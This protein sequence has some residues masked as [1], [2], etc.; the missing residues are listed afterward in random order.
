MSESRRKDDQQ[1]HEFLSVLRSF[2]HAM[3][4]TRDTEGGLRS[5]PMAIAETTESGKLWFISNVQSGKQ[6]ELAEDPDVNVAM[7]G[8]GRFLSIT[9]RARVVRDSGKAEELWSE[10]QRVWFSGPHDPDLVLIEVRPNAAE[11]WDGSG[12]N[13][14]KYLFA[15][16]GAIVTG[17]K[18]SDDERVH[19]KLT[20]DS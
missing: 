12:L 10:A 7:Q 20:F 19:G 4:V 17:R 13:G 18:L 14:L 15:E 9:G 5:R 2:E 3:L 11:Y 6:D 8:G 1:Q 16:A